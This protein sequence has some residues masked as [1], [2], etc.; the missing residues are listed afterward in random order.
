MRNDFD[1]NI[2]HSKNSHLTFLWFIFSLKQPCK[3]VA[4]FSSFLYQRYYEKVGMNSPIICLICVSPYTPQVGHKAELFVL[5]PMGTSKE[6]K[7]VIAGQYALSEGATRNCI[8]FSVLLDSIWIVFV[9]EIMCLIYIV[10]VLLWSSKHFMD[11]L[12]NP[13]AWARCLAAFV[14]P[15]WSGRLQF[16][17]CH[18]AGMCKVF[19]R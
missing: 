4:L 16:K 14:L 17:G 15:L 5:F 2:T 13:K 18:C 12:I 8:F 10:P 7:E 11:T 19:R 6:W 1:F 3:C 9:T